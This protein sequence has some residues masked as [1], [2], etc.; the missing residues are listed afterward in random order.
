MYTVIRIY[1]LVLWEGEYGEGKMS[2]HDGLRLIVRL[3]DGNVYSPIIM[4]GFK[5][6]LWD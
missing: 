2:G 3:L 5:G 6:L 4:A 1:C